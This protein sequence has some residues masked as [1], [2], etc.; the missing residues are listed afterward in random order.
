MTLATSGISVGNDILS[1]TRSGNRTASAST[2]AGGFSGSYAYDLAGRMT[3]DGLRGHRYTYNLK[4]MTQNVC[5]SSGTALVT[6]AYHEGGTKK[7]SHTPTEAEG[8]ITDQSNTP[9]QAARCRM[10]IWTSSISATAFTG[11]MRTEHGR[12]SGL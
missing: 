9:S 7:A 10:L 4:G 5:D 2:S 12:P 11:K 6:Y 1:F 3:T 8:C